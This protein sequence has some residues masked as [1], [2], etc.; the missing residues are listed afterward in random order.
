MQPFVLGLGLLAAAVV[1]KV[2]VGIW[3]AL[4]VPAALQHIP[5]IPP[6]LLAKKLIVDKFDAVR[7]YNLA[8]SLFGFQPYHMRFALGKWYL[9]IQDPVA[10]KAVLLAAKV[11]DKYVPSKHMKN[12]LFL[13]FMDNNIYW[14]HPDEFDPERFADEANDGFTSARNPAWMPF[15]AGVRQCPGMSFAMVEM[16]VMLSILLRLYEIK[17]E[18]DADEPLKFTVAAPQLSPTNIRVSF[19]SRF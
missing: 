19:K 14:R 8:V 18:M 17:L 2:V 12:G 11:C 13:S 9:H 1:V 4:R 7:L 15:G 5:R 6:W 16:R 10:A 3:S